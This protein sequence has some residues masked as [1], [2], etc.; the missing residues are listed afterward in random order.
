MRL[1]APPR[2]VFGERSEEDVRSILASAEK[3]VM[4]DT[5][6]HGSLRDALSSL[7]GQTRTH[8]A[9]ATGSFADNP[10]DTLVGGALT[11]LGAAISLAVFALADDCGENSA[12]E[13]ACFALLS[14]ST[15][16]FEHRGHG[17]SQGGMTFGRQLTRPVMP[18]EPRA[19]PG[20]LL[21]LV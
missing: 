15:H 6:W 1:F 3:W 17:P 10:A 8:M 4:G 11:A 14:R 18:F 13:L 16:H 19:L 20:T 9:D 5:G 2:K 21:V 7:S 12:S